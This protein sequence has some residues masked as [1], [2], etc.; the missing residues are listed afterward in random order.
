M[1]NTLKKKTLQIYKIDL[2]TLRQYECLS[3]TNTYLPA[4]LGFTAKQSFSIRFKPHLI[5]CYEK[6][7]IAKYYIQ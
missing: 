2:F 4:G 1:R 6:I 7:F 5:L 3:L